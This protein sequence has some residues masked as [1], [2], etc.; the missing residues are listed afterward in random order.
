MTGLEKLLQ[1]LSANQQPTFRPTAIEGL[2]K[3]QQAEMKPYSPETFQPG[4]LNQ[5][6]MGK[7][8]GLIGASFAP[9]AGFS[10]FAGTYPSASGGTEPSAAQNLQQGNYFTSAL[11]TLGAFGDAATATGAALSPLGLAAGI[12]VGSI[13]KAPRA[14]QKGVQGLIDTVKPKLDELGF[15]SQVEKSVMDIPQQKGTGQQFLAQIKKTAGVK[16]EEL[17]YT[18]LDTFLANK[19]TVT[20]GEIQDY[21]DT[22]RVQVQ[23]VTLGSPDQAQIA[24]QL[25]GDI[26]E[27]LEAGQVFDDDAANFLER[28]QSARLSGRRDSQSESSLEEYLK[29]A[30]DNRTI[31]EIENISKEMAGDTTKFSEY[32]IPGGENYRELLLTLPAKQKPNRFTLRNNES[33]GT[34]G[35][36]DTMEE[37][38]EFMQTTPRDDIRSGNFSVQE[39]TSGTEPVYQSSHFDQPNILAHM[40]VNDRTID[41]KPTMFIEEVQSDWHQAGRKQGYKNGQERKATKANKME[42]YWEVRDQNDQFITNVIDTRQDE[43]GA[44]ATANA[45]LAENDPMRMASDN[46]VPDA[47][48]KTS[49]DELTLKRAIKMASDD[50]YEQIAFTTGK[51]QADRYDLSR[52][53]E[54]INVNR[55]GGGRREVAVNVKNN[56]SFSLQVDK[57]GRVEGANVTAGEF[58]GKQL[59]DIVGKDMASQIMEAKTGQSFTGLELDIGGEGMKGFYDKMLPKK[60]EKIGK[61]Y[62]A[63][64][65]KSTMQTP[66]GDVEVWTFNIPKEMRET[67]KEQGQPLFQIGAGA[68]LGGLLATEEEQY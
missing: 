2:L 42:G 26:R 38:Q 40:R 47:P 33:G 17:Q 35:S 36:F 50:G 66:D 29:T 3:P 9:G 58:V 52:Q 48:F 19:P 4:L 45:R 49:W 20:K 63:K 65:T 8:L 53:V 21:L 41:G 30:G 24:S 32:T 14:A 7:Q 12:G 10:D 57:N 27:I 60:L 18:G 16:P 31:S 15:F 67:V 55:T 22:N 68:G 25:S 23:E 64:P 11:Q 37:A 6:S 5:P 56:T 39:T 62:G 43:A 54:S 51:T 28:Y 1:Q 46:R 34:V 13:A 44:L 59:S 61:K